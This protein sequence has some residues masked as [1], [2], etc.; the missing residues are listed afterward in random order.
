MST[1]SPSG[2]RRGSR[3]SGTGSPGRRSRRSRPSIGSSTAARMPRSPARLSA[4]FGLASVSENTVVMPSRGSG[5]AARGRGARGGL[6]VGGEAGD[7]DA[8]RGRSGGRG[9]RTRRGSTTIVSRRGSRR[10]RSRSPG[11]G[12]P[13]RAA[14]PARLRGVVRG[15]GRV[16]RREPVARRRRRPRR[17]WS[18]PARSAGRRRS[19]R[20]RACA[21][22]VDD[23]VRGRPGRRRRRRR[24]EAPLVDQHVGVRDLA[25]SAGRSSSRSCGSCPGWVRLVTSACVAGDPL[26]DVLQRVERGHHRGRSVRG[27]GRRAPRARRRGGARQRR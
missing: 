24:L 25:R 17:A 13:G 9:S 8:P 19:G 1:R 22:R 5:P 18:G 26:G 10:D 4:N 21:A 27:A 16:G 20:G 12:R 23:V 3:A 6:G 14:R 11:R 2:G 7:A 15:V